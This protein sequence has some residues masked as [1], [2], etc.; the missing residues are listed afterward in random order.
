MPDA[1]GTIKRRTLHEQVM[2]QLA[3]HIRKGKLKPGDPLPPERE[4]AERLQ[5]SRATIREALRMMEHQSLI[6]SHHG[7]G[8]FIAEGEAGSLAKAMTQFALQDIFEA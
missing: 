4:L 5:V 3:A 7:S 6:V 1:L 8:N 2:V